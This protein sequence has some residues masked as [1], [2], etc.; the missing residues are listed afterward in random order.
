MKD[1]ADN[2]L[3]RNE[4][5]EFCWAKNYGV[6]EKDLILKTYKDYFQ[7]QCIQG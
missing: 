7:T 1:Y 6:N 5:P 2:S 4:I 3:I